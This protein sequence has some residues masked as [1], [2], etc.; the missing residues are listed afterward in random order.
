M[1]RMADSTA[2]KDFNTSNEKSECPGVSTRF[3]RYF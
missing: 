3:R 1:S 2:Y